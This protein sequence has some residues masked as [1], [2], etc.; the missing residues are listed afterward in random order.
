MVSVVMP[1]YNEADIIEASV[2]EWHEEVIA[3]LPGAELIVVDDCS[4]DATGETLAR[5]ARELPGLR[6]VRPPQNGGHGRAL[7]FGFRQTSCP[8]VL[9]TDSDRQHVP[10]EFWELWKRREGHDFVFGVRS[11]REDGSFRVI[12]TTTM[13]ML[14]LLVWGEW[15]RDANCPFK[16]MS[17]PALERVLD[18]IPED[19]FIP[20]VM[21]SI[22]VRK[23][24]FRY[25]E[26]PVTHL[27]RR[28]GSQS[29]KGM[30]KWFRVGR[31][32]FGQL[33]AL[34]LSGDF[35]LANAIAPQSEP[36]NAGEQ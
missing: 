33:L 36:A 19:S 8:Y 28:G 5:L 24:A 29:L 11:T 17:K 15:I 30:V 31:R 10:A 23:M 1:A 12:V 6:P 32:C 21:L 35:A 22:L 16:L 3:K 27:P 2:R 7:R 9:Q 34:R 14:N 4:T 20:M 25:A 26:V 18:R 13:R